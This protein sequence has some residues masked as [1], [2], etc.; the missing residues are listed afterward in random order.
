MS[1]ISQ[2]CS[3][4]FTSADCMPVLAECCDSWRHWCQTQYTGA[5][6]DIRTCVRGFG[7]AV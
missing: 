7:C 2:T 1:L 6:G 4:G 3:C 5:Y